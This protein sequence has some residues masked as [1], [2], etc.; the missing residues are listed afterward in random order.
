M[1]ESVKRRG[2]SGPTIGAMVRCSGRVAMRR[3]KATFG[4]PPRDTRPMQEDPLEVVRRYHEAVAARD[5]DA[6]VA[7]LGEDIEFLTVDSPL[8]LEPVYRGHD[9][10]RRFFRDWV[11]AWESTGYA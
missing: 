6:I 10:M 2:S 9:G 7:L 3:S 5:R 1:P 4:S 8:D 11:G